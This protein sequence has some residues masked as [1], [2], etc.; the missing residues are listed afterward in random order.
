MGTNGS[1]NSSSN[2]VRPRGL[3]QEPTRRP[4]P[5]LVPLSQA[6]TAAAATAELNHVQ[7]TPRGLGQRV[8]GQGAGG[9]RSLSGHSPYHHGQQP[10]GT[11]H[12]RSLTSTPQK[13]IRLRAE[14]ESHEGLPQV[15]SKLSAL[16]L[17]LQPPCAPSL[18]L[19][20]VESA[21]FCPSCSLS[22]LAPC[23]LTLAWCQRCSWWS[24]LADKQASSRRRT[25][26]E[27]SKH[28]QKFTTALL[29]IAVSS[30][31]AAP[32]AVRASGG[33]WLVGTLTRLELCCI[34]KQSS[35][36]DAASRWCAGGK[37]GLC[38]PRKVSAFESHPL[39]LTHSPWQ[40]KVVPR[41]TQSG[42]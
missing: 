6:S 12:V 42:L 17:S 30:S 38:F 5:A 11:F 41:A 34:I 2:Q 15:G 16:L 18:L 33:R 32:C 7:A 4:A 20:K 24:Y 31:A 29:D 13:G 35:R 9:G 25:S 26:E 14:Q 3:P 36:R 10:P 8:G 19:I 40:P 1:S 28:P 39:W 23:W 22:R 27:Q 37:S 21:R